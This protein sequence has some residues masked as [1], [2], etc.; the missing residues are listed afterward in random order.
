MKK[1]ILVIAMFL[2][3]TACNK[4]AQQEVQSSNSEIKLELL[5]EHDGCKVYRFVDGG[6][7]VYWSDCRGNMSTS[8]YQ[9]H[10]KSVTTKYQQS[11]SDGR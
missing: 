10:G 5:F 8:Y 7:N 4:E 6:R 2:L 9:S 11:L 1:S 3:L